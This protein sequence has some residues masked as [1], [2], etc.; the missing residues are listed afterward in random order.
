MV[1]T[2]RWTIGGP[3]LVLVCESFELRLTNYVTDYLSD[4]VKA[5]YLLKNSFAIQFSSYFDGNMSLRRSFCTGSRDSFYRMDL[6]A[7]PTS[8]HLEA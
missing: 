2:L 5:R 3:K 1:R 7:I 6:C 4:L 8:F